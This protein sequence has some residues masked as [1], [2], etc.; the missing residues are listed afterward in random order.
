MRSHTSTKSLPKSSFTPARSPLLQRKC[1][2][3][4]SAGLTGKCSACEDKSLTLQRRSK[5][6]TETTAEV[7]P[8]VHEVLSSSGQPLD[9]QTL[10][11]MGSHFE[12]DFSR[13]SVHTD[14]KAAESAQAINALAYTVGQNIVFGAGQFAPNT[15]TGKRILAH[16]LTHVVQQSHQGLTPSLQRQSSAGTESDAL[17]VEADKIAQN[18]V[19][20]PT[21]KASSLQKKKTKKAVSSLLTFAQV[22]KYI[23]SNNNSSLS[24]E[25]LLCLIWKES[26]FDPKTKNSSSSATGLMQMTK[27]A[28]TEVNKNTPKG[29][30]F[31]HS[32][33]TDPEKNIACGTYYLTI[34]IK[35][36]KGNIKKGVEG[37]GTGAGYAD[38]ILDCETC[39]Q[40]Q[41]AEP[42][43]CLFTIHK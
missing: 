13:V 7:P 6:Q 18:V 10:N 43:D 21:K 29:V 27:G 41:P 14:S 16:E 1:D 42:N 33:M 31:N 3:G 4:N 8:I 19:K 40:K 28:V 26:G 17:E 5:N 37:F 20:S 24:K 34:R 9:H 30:H 39:L 32:E 38:K 2:C 22:E 15:T 25:F 11:F 23:L 36:A 12:H 35:W